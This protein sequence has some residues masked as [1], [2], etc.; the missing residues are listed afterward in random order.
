MKESPIDADQFVTIAYDFGPKCMQEIC[1]FLYSSNIKIL[2]LDK[3][4]IGDEGV[5]SLS[6]IIKNL[7]L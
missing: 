3:N 2:N 1:N 5:R 7:C 6:K 4:P